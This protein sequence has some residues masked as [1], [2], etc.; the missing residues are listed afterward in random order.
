MEHSVNGK[1]HRWI[2]LSAS[3]AWCS[4][5][6]AIRLHVGRKAEIRLPMWAIMR[7]RKA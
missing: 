4:E 5:C 6:G 2:D 1:A 3:V 7:K